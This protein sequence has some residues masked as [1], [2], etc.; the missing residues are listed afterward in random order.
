MTNRDEEAADS[1][2]EVKDS[3]MEAK[4]DE[5][6]VSITE[7]SKESIITAASMGTRQLNA[8][9]TRYLQTWDV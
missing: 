1:K 4:V 3:A 8:Q 9:A 7:G 6:E 5:A 2:E